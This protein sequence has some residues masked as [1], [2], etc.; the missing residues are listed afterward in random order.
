MSIGSVKPSETQRLVSGS[1]TVPVPHETWVARARCA[2]TTAARRDN[3]TGIWR[4]RSQKFSGEAAF[5]H[6]LVGG[7]LEWVCAPRVARGNNITHILRRPENITG[8]ANSPA[9]HGKKKVCQSTFGLFKM[10][11]AGIGE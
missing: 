11:H 2:R 10:I 6:F 7:N 8:E 4:N 9:F 5:Y 3:I 1:R